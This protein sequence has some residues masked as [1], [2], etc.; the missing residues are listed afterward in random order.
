M[1]QV[2]QNF[3]DL[4]HRM[5]DA[6]GDIV[7]AAFR[8]GFDTQTK[9][10]KT[11][12]TDIDKAVERAVRELVAAHAPDHGVIGEE[13]PAE[14]PDADFV[15][16]V[17]PIDGTKSFICGIPLFG[18]LIAL[19]HGGD[20]VLGVVDQPIMRERWIGADGHGASMNGKPIGTRACPKLA[21]AV[22]TTS[23]P[24]DYAAFA[25]DDMRPVH[26][27]GKWVMYGG[28]CYDYGLL[29]MGFHDVMIDADLH[30]HDYAAPAALIRNAGG[31]VSDWRGAPLGPA[32]DGR[33]LAVG[34]PAL[35]EQCLALIGG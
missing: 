12:V 1:K 18:T 19:R 5:A 34:D 29:A 26:K 10:D 32:S 4:A 23:G 3:L 8:Q 14:R 27:A 9:A 31:I 13:Y 30:E 28:E 20:Y 11:P 2:P 21:D 22:V 15:W 7:R 33:I 17:D 25:Y 16:I 24:D 6:S 35:H